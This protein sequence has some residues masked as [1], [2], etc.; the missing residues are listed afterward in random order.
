ME[1][2][3]KKLKLRTKNEKR[4]RW[5]TNN[6]YRYQDASISILVHAGFL[7]GGKNRGI[8]EP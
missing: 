3:T 5:G 4:G 6:V 8:T 7:R 2:E 1:V